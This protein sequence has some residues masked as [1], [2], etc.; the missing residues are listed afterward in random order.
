[1][2]ITN[3]LGDD[4]KKRILRQYR[5]VPV[6]HTR[7]LNG[8]TLRCCCGR[9][10]K[11]RYYQFDAVDRTADKA[12]GVAYAGD[13]CADRFID[14]SNEL[15][16]EL[17]EARIPSLPFFD[18]LEGEP[19][20]AEGGGRGNGSGQA[21]VAMDPLNVEV[22]RA[23]NLTLICWDTA[24]RPGSL[25]SQR[26]EEIHRFPDRPVYDWKVKLVNTAISKGGRRLSTM[27]ETLRQTNPTLRHFEFPLMEAALRGLDP[28]PVSYL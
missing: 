22:M 24:P 21:R 3:G 14:L 12:V 23:I 5:L 13:H 26:L 8:K 28:P 15:A 16:Q 9:P 6:M 27:L 17:G 20:V 25:F 19:R 11:D 7:P 2:L 1:M 4:N 18:P 10:V